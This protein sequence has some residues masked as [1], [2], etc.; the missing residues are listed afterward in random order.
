MQQ[1]LSI[2]CI[3]LVSGVCAASCKLLRCRVNLRNMTF[4]EI[5]NKADTP[6]TITSGDFCQQRKIWI[7]SADKTLSYDTKIG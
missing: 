2:T 4:T 7:L 3:S 6:A 1:T 5:Y